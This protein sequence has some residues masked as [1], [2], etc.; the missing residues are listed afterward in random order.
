MK[1][2]AR[3][4]FLMAGDL[5]VIHLSFLATYWLIAWFDPNVSA[6]PAFVRSLQVIWLVAL[7]HVICLY[8]ADL[9]RTDR[10]RRR[11]QFHVRVIITIL[12]ASA[13]SSAVLFFVPEYILGRRPLLLN[14]A[15]L[16]VVLLTWRELV[17]HIFPGRTRRLAIV[18][19]AEL[20][21]EYR[22]HLEEAGDLHLEIVGTFVVE[23]QN[24]EQEGTGALVEFIEKTRPGTLAI[25]LSSYRTRAEEVHAIFQLQRTGLHIVDAHEFFKDISERFALSGLT[26][27]VVLA[28]IT[29]AEAAG[30]AYYGTKR[31]LDFCGS[32][33]LLLL[34]F[35][36]VLCAAIAIRLESPGPVLF[37]QERL[38]LG[39]KPF[40][41]FKLRTMVAN[42]EADGPQRTSANDSRIT[43][44]GAL[45]R[46]LRIDELPQL[47]NVLL[48]QMS[49]VGPRPI[50]EHFVNQW[51]REVPLYDLKLLTAPGLTGWTQVAY[52]MASVN[53]DQWVKMAYDLYYLE[54]QSL[55]FDVYILIRTLR[56][57]VSSRRQFG[58]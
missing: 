8:S 19:S 43:R 27:T 48:G 29:R 49:L 32:L 4:L 22:A 25:D 41:C 10:R 39:G 37:V 40:N 1:R 17:R 23:E 13:L 58:K 57:I 9:Y 15:V 26:P 30:A 16:I 56:I 38:G 35:P 31:A 18:G 53:E 5:V 51:S 44:V 28:A 14:T 36:I 6:W 47:I 2:N 54:R 12:I 20:I 52:D 24:E 42:A 50:R 11:R 45:L 3:T 34:S 46:K 7:L 33:V 55:V 21:E